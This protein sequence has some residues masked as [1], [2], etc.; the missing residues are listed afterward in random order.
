MNY[1]K[2][3]EINRNYLKS[4]HISQSTI[5]IRTHPNQHLSQSAPIS[6]S[7]YPNQHPSQSAPIPSIIHPNKDPSQS[8]PNLSIYQDYS[9]KDVIKIVIS[10]NHYHDIQFYSILHQNHKKKSQAFIPISTHPKH[11]YQSAPISSI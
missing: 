8:A 10:K 7:I 2:L 1:L 3:L 11:L 4:F 6:I 9:Q 5:S